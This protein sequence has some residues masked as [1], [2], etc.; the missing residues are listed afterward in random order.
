MNKILNIGID[1]RMAKESGIGRYIS[2]IVRN[3][4]ETDKDNLYTLYV[5]QEDYF[6]D[7]SLPKNF[8]KIVAPFR[9]HSFSE[10]FSFNSLIKSGNHDLMHFPQTNYP[11]MYSGKFM[12]TI[13]DLTMVKFATGRAST[14]FYP[15]YLI[16]LLFFKLILRMALKN[17]SKIITVSNFVKNEIVRDYKIDSDKIQVIYNG[18]DSKLAYNPQDLSYFQKTYNVAK[19]FIF[20]IGNAYPH[21]NLERLILAFTTFNQQNKYN[22]VLAGKSDFFYERLKEN[23]KNLENIKFIGELSDQELSKFYSSAEFFVYPSMS[24]GFGI[25]IVEALGLRSKVCCSNN[26]VFPEIAESNAVYF[27]PFDIEDM[28][29]AFNKTI[30]SEKKISLEE[31]KKLTEKFNWKISTLMHHNLYEKA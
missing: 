9:W 22:L 3:L 8:T 13:H 15:F 10:Q 12:I 30:S 5:Y 1:C 29:L 28:I 6:T 7:I 17:S 2:N 11:I 19:P 4:A 27:N 23:F 26:S 16:K 25:Q 31:I 18:I 24:E 20:Y 21:K 14:L